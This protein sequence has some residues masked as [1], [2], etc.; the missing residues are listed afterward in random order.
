MSVCLAFVG[1]FVKVVGDN[2]PGETPWEQALK[3]WRTAFKKS[4]KSSLQV[5][6][7]YLEVSNIHRPIGGPAQLLESKKLVS[8]TGVRD[9]AT[10]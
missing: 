6:I 8:E 1:V 9:N 4:Q 7:F 5:F 2:L 3:K 10:G